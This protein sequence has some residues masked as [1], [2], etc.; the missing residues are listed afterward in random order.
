MAELDKAKKIRTQHRRLHTAACN[1]LRIDLEN[2][3]EIKCE[4]EFSRLQMINEDLNQVNLQIQ[5]LILETAKDDE[6]NKEFDDA[7]EYK[8][9]FMSVQ[10]ALERLQR[11]L[12]I[13]EAD[14]RSE[15]TNNSGPKDGVEEK[16]KKNSTSGINRLQFMP[17]LELSHFD[18]HPR[19]WL[20]FWSKFRR[21]HDSPEL[22]AIDKLSYLNQYTSG[23]A[24][25]VV[26]IYPLEEVN[27]QKAIDHLKERFASEKILVRHYVSQI[28]EIVLKSVKTNLA[29]E[30]LYYELEGYIRALKTLN[31]ETDKYSDFLCP[32]VEASLGDEQLLAWQRFKSGVNSSSSVSTSSVN[33]DALEDELGQLMNYL[34]FEVE[35]LERVKE[36]RESFV[37]NSSK[38]CKEKAESV[39]K[40]PKFTPTAA[41]MIKTE[42]AGCVFCNEQHDSGDCPSVRKLDLVERRKRLMTRGGCFRCLKRGHISQ[43]CADRSKC[44]ICLGSHH[45]LLCQKAWF[46]RSDSAS[47]S[48]RDHLGKSKSHEPKTRDTQTE[49]QLKPK[50][51]TN[52]IATCSRFRN[53]CYLATFKVKV[54]SPEGK[55]VVRAMLDIGSQ[56]TSI[57]ESVGKELKFPI[58]EKEY[59]CSSLYGGVQ[60]PGRFYNRC[61]IGLES[62]VNDNFLQITAL[63][64]KVINNTVPVMPTPL[65]EEFP[66]IEFTDYGDEAGPIEL[67]IGA[68]LYGS[69]VTGQM[70]V[71]EDGL[72]AIQTIFGWAVAGGGGKQTL[73]NL[74]INR[75]LRTTHLPDLWELDLMG[76]QEPSILDEKKALEK[77]TVVHFNNHTKRL[78]DGRY[79]IELPWLCERE[80]LPNNRSLAL[81]RFER[82]AGKL[83]AERFSAYD[84]VFREWKDLD[85]I[86]VV[87]VEEEIG[88]FLP[89]RPVLTLHKETTKVRPVFDA[90]AH[91]VGAV[92][93][94]DCLSTGPNLLE[95]ILPLIIRFRLN[96]FGLVADIEKAFLQISVAEE[97]RKYLRFFWYDED[98]NLKVFQH[99]RVVFGICSSPFILNA[100]IVKHLDEIEVDQEVSEET[101]VRLKRAFYVD[102]C[103]LS[104][105]EV[106]E[107][108][109]FIQ[110][111]KSV[112][113]NACFNLRGWISNVSEDFQPD[114]NKTVLGL[115]WQVQQDTLSCDFRFNLTDFTDNLTKRQMLSLANRVFDPV[116]FTVPVMLEPKILLQQTWD[117]NVKWDEPLPEDLM[118][119][120]RLWVDQLE[121]LKLC[122]I[123]RW[124]LPNRSEIN[125]GTSLH[126]FCD[127][128]ADAFAG[129]IFI[130]SK[131]SVEIAVRLVLGK[132]KVTP[133]KRKLTIPKLELL[134]ATLACRL[135]A[136]VV[137]ELPELPVYFWSD[138]SIA[139]TWI[140]KEEKWTPF[141]KNR[142]D[143]IRK[144]S[145]QN[146]WFHVPGK[147]NAADLLTRGCSAEKLIEN[148]WW[149]TPAWLLMAD[150][151][152]EY[153]QT[154]SF[155]QEADQEKRIT[156]NLHR[157]Q[158][159]EGKEIIESLN[160]RFSK[161][162]KIIRC[163][164]W[165]ERF[166]FN[167]RNR[168][169]H[170]SGELSTEEVTEAEKTV[171]KFMQL[172]LDEERL[173]KNL[174]IFVDSK[175]L[176]RVKT[177]LVQDLEVGFSH[178]PVLL[179]SNHE[180]VDKLI[181]EKHLILSHAGTL[182]L[183]TL[184]RTDFWILRARKTIRKRV[185]GCYRC[186]RFSAK[187]AEATL[188]PLPLG[189]VTTGK[190]FNVVGVDLAGPLF[191]KSKEK[192]WILL[193]TCAVYRAVHLE[194]VEAASTESFLL[195]FRRF[196]A[197]RGRVSLV[198]SDNGTNFVGANNLLE[199]VEWNEIQKFSSI[200]R[201]EWRF[202]PPTASWWGGFWERLVGV[203]K[204]SLRRCLG[205]ASL[206]L[207]ELSTTVCEVEGIV[208]SRPLTYV[209][210]DL[211]ELEPLTPAHFIQPN[212]DTATDDFDEIDRQ[213]LLSR[214]AHLE[215]VREHLRQR[216]VKEYLSLLVGHSK[217]GT[218]VREGDIV[219]VGTDNT[220]RISWPLGRVVAVMPGSDEVVRLV[221]VKTA[222]G[223]FLRPVQRLYP[224]EVRDGCDLRI[225]KESDT[226]I[227]TEDSALS[228]DIKPLLENKLSRSGRT[229][230]LPPRYSD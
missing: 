103:I 196:I 227:G 93:L 45:V 128:S 100:V 7:E 216:F 148:Q 12:T 219:L 23:K 86:E 67:L 53:C 30:K 211:E 65:L 184:L 198:Y 29:F 10:I 26:Q 14:A 206:S 150:E 47:G 121:L 61:S 27:Y 24:K 106:E 129:C 25:S 161:Y 145:D 177:R 81:K 5:D 228:S 221:K 111:A 165:V 28:L 63:E 134:G 191:L 71:A 33:N 220:K 126:V 202:N 95:N 190:A 158:F 218:S 72:T 143:E 213:Q 31:I 189:R 142:V 97:D 1:R 44:V 159:L 163:L 127:A 116:G 117:R 139:L 70:L 181:V 51:K 19:S 144:F 50:E 4:L 192:V 48:S 58:I 122:R 64:D 74:V 46:E 169:S 193:V 75:C 120:A 208:N 201:I 82:V 87:E 98:K 204:G 226:A 125:E 59:L 199:R 119:R 94:N 109:Q 118:K 160:Q 156:V 39:P 15:K 194:I 20:T 146:R 225:D 210:E 114:V 110:E 107:C 56:S 34:S 224:L 3:D 66:G 37:H 9:N 151:D 113:S 153:Y 187:E 91:V 209:S 76:I 92:S 115:L 155:D 141:V 176:R 123:P 133:L 215:K 57:L 42:E 130:R 182:S 60:Q 171:L 55:R 43:K 185:K 17:K 170:R 89:H 131:D 77:E 175:G 167:C 178:E 180:L 138:S 99:R 62:L 223:E 32:L 137:K 207:E 105:S 83:N 186:K 102:D 214:S 230:K 205:K 84:K 40:S 52:V 2:G 152:W 200:R 179:P 172:G 168:S 135:Y 229:I 147:F 38:P 6:L 96:R 69:V 140:R 157:L 108:M 217:K 174:E 88:H 21:I 79:E 183:M 36:V 22:D 164:A 124:I 162:T 203:M 136:T 85:I 188:A 49:S 132:G 212:S 90:S 13:E 54:C 104:L 35:N 78:S 41:V 101:I 11:K 173:P 195:A 68:D 112:M 149:D 73:G 222:K 154:V 16:P 18:G 8:S 80:K 166:I 197:R